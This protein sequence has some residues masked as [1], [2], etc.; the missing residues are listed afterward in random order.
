MAGKTLSDAQI[1]EKS[2]PGARLGRVRWT[3]CAML[4]V[5][6]SIDYMAVR[7]SRS[8]SQPSSPDSGLR[9]H[10]DRL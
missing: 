4:F 9:S 7:S 10:H 3:I 6:T 2:S 8:S 1:E 5:T